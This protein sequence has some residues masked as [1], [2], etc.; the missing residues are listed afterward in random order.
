MCV[1]VLYF[2]IIVILFEGSQSQAGFQK[3]KLL[4][5]FQ[6]NKKNDSKLRKENEKKCGVGDC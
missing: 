4:S 5:N 2:W 1:C 3:K 6:K